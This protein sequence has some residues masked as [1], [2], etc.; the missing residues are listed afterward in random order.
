MNGPR[1]WFIRDDILR[2]L[3][4]AA[5]EGDKTPEDLIALLEEHGAT[6]EIQ[7]PFPGEP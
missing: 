3:L 1:Y 7:L 2:M 6:T 5:H 4:I